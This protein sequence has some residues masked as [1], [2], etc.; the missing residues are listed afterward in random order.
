MKTP[1]EY[2]TTRIWV[3]TRTILRMLHALTG[4]SVVSILHRLAEQELE[5]VQKQQ[6]HIDQQ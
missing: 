3:K 4:E 5:R 1:P 2:V 6:Q